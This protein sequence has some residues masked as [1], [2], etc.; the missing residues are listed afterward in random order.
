MVSGSNL[1]REFVRRYALWLAAL[2]YSTDTKRRY[3]RIAGEF[4]DLLGRRK[5]DRSTNW[6]IRRFLILKSR[7]GRRY[8]SLYDTL[9]ALRSF[10]EFLSLGGISSVIPL[11]N[12]RIRAPRRDVPAV[13][14]AN[15]I[16]RLI[17]AARE[18]REVALVELLYA[19]GCRN[20]ELANIK[21]EDIDFESRTILV[22]GKLS[23]SRYVVFGDLAYRAIKTYLAGRR[24]GYLFQPGRCQKGSVYKSSDGD[25][26]V[27]E[28]SVY[29]PDRS[30]ARRRIVIPLGRP[31]KMSLGQAWRTFKKHMDWLPTIR[32]LAP[33]P[34]AT[35]TIRR[36]LYRLA[37]RAGMERITPREVRHCFAT[38]LLDGG[39]DTCEIQELLGHSSLKSTQIYIHVGRKKLLEV[40]D[41]CHPRGNHY[42]VERTS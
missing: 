27:G 5:V 14:S 6:D 3:S 26:W 15:K 24:F 30:P 25:T 39:A 13:S 18:P 29:T 21:V 23:K 1:N 31:S 11:R 36:I 9:T 41:R 17:K 8:P 4:C 42:N 12:V 28:V 7:G 10:F 20:K 16:L 38:H 35:H 33:R 40:F 19:T 34:M 32:P 2:R 22:S 37:L